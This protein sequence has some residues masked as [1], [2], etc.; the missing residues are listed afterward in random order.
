MTGFGL[1]LTVYLRFYPQRRLFPALR[2]FFCGA[3]GGKG[4]R[5]GISAFGASAAAL[6][7]SLGTGNI[8]GVA[9]ALTAGGPGAVFWMWVSALLGMS[10]KYAEIF[11]SVRFR[12][13]GDGSPMRYI[14]QAWGGN[15]LSCVFACGC[16]GASFGVGNMAQASAAAD[17]IEAAFHLPAVYTGILLMLAVGCVMLGGKNRIVSASERLIPLIGGIYLLGASLVILSRLNRL[18][19]M[20]LLI[21]R[22]AFSVQSAA[23]GLAGIFVS[24]AFRSGITRGIFTNEAGMGSSPIIH[25]AAECDS[26]SDEGLWGVA[27]VALDTLIMCTMT[28]AVLLLTDSLSGGLDGAELTVA[29]FSSVLGDGAGYFLGIATALFAFSSILSWSWCGESA[30]AYLGAG[31]RGRW[32]YR[33]LFLAAVLVGSCFPIQTVLSISD[34][35]NFYMSVPNLLAIF[36]LRKTIVNETLSLSR[37]VSASV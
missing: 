27:E 34:L 36:R 35:L 17:S 18:P 8:A 1:Y 9:A 33:C 37:T 31:K 23:G 11:L 13:D 22:D 24:R 20:L 28:A 29:A 6:A 3:A 16:I 19:G 12:K 32:G 21:L 30:L 15:T 7:G 26:P 4:R 2:R 25:G 14:E 5:S 10:L